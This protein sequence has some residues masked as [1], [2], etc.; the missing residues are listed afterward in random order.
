MSRGQSPPQN[1]DALMNSRTGLNLFTILVAG[2][3]TCFTVFL[4]HSFGTRALGRNGVVA[5][6]L[7]LLYACAMED[8]ASLLF[9]GIFLFALVIQ[10]LKTFQL[11]RA[12]V[13][14]HS[15]YAGYPWLAMRCPL[16]RSEGTAKWLE[17]AFCLLIGSCLCPLSEPLGLFVTLGMFSLMFVRGFETQIM[18]NRM[19]AM[20]DSAIEQRN[21]AAI[22]RGESHL[23]DF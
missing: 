9:L 23:S 7:I 2:H 19:R 13:E 16:V 17:P 14:W 21:M 5:C 11:Y 10:R 4:R 12:G 3:A 22:F 1:F 15:Y 18:A 6:L 20:R 8:P